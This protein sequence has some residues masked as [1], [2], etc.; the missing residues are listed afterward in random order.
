LG[1]SFLSRFSRV[2]FDYDKQMLVLE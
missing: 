1:Q 2:S